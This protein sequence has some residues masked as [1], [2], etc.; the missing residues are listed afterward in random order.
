MKTLLLLA[1][2]AL[3]G[4]A[5]VTQTLTSETRDEKGVTEK[6]SLTVTVRAAGDAK[7]A[8]EKMRA[9][10]G[11]TLSTGV[12]GQFQEAAAPDLNLLLQLL[13]ATAK[14]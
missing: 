9:S 1:L 10:N 7:Q 4:C 2:L 14:P 8:L 3:T 13:K 11:K 12:E 6:R 5:S